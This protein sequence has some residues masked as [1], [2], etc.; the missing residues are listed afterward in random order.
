MFNLIKYNIYVM[1][2]LIKLYFYKLGLI[3]SN[4]KFNLC[5]PCLD[6]KL[7]FLQNLITWNLHSYI[8]EG[9]DKALFRKKI[10]G[11]VLNTWLPKVSMF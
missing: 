7:T 4:S 8:L 1:F 11:T 3:S 5:M 9:L 2:F 6:L 10:L